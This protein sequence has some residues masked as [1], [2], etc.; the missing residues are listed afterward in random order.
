MS[1]H[2]LWLAL[3]RALR[4]ALIR[5][6]EALEE[7]P[8][9]PADPSPTSFD[10]GPPE[11]WLE[12]V[13]RSAPQLLKYEG[14]PASPVPPRF[15][16]EPPNPGPSTSTPERRCNTP[17]PSS[18]TSMRIF[19]LSRA[20]GDREE[21]S[22]E[23]RTRR[24]GSPAVVRDRASRPPR[25]ATFLKARSRATRGDS[26][27]PDSPRNQQQHTT[28]KP[29]LPRDASTLPRTRKPEPAPRTEPPRLHTEA[30]AQTP[31]AT[32]SNPAEEVPPLASS[33]GTSRTSM[34]LSLSAP[35]PEPPRLQWPS[36][37]TAPPVRS[38]R[39]VTELPPP[40]DLND[41][42]PALPDLPPFI[43]TTIRDREEGAVDGE[44]LRRL[45]E[46]QR[47]TAWTA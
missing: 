29:P 27:P 12:R 14:G 3:R 45:D 33:A 39:A 11:R 40:P 36:V 10:A 15:R 43:P 26:V 44:H 8:S 46:E 16:P 9:P 41:R 7:R 13:R 47:G 20:T 4:R 5:G 21:H 37:D 38:R 23:P 22:D 34:S 6:L 1:G 28:A 31:T 17:R 24:D 42:W 30:P 18:K 2:D 32:R 35:E 25:I 19:R